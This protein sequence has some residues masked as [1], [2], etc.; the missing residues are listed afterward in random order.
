[1]IADAARAARALTALDVAG[2]PWSLALS[3]WLGA[4][5]VL[6]ESGG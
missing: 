3:R 1:V 2:W 6:E 4:L 5:V